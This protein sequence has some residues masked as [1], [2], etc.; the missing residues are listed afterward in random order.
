[1]QPDK[2]LNKFLIYAHLASNTERKRKYDLAAQFWER[3]LT[4]SLNNDNIEWAIR[5]KS[6]CLKQVMLN[7]Q[8]KAP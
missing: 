3:A 1:M 4:H 5:R 2:P 7:K 6:F 8:K